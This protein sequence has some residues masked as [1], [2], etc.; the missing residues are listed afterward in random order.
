[1]QSIDVIERE[2]APGV[3]TVEAIGRD[4]EIYQALFYGPQ[5]RHRALEYAQFKYDFRSPRQ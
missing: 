5:A 4:G 3:W 1:M 2:D